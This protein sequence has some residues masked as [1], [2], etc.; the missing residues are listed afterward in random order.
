M[1]IDENIDCF[2]H[3]DD[4]NIIE[5]INGRRNDISVE[6]DSLKSFECAEKNNLTKCTNTQAMKCLKVL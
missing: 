3:I 2:E 5:N 1:S 6:K 4:N